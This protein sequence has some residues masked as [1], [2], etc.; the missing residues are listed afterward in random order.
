MSNVKLLII[1]GNVHTQAM[2]IERFPQSNQSNI[3]ERNRTIE[4]RLSNT[5]EFQSNITAILW[6]NCVRLC[7]IGFDCVRLC[8]IVFDYVRLFRFD[9]ISELILMVIQSKPSPLLRVNP[10]CLNLILN[11]YLFHFKKPK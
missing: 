1:K 4:I 8:S 5:I 7:S 9:L 2:S 11:A 10:L 3:I 6:L